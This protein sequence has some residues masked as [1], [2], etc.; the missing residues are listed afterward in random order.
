MKRTAWMIRLALCAL[1]VAAIA[2]PADAAEK[3]IL[4]YLRGS[5]GAPI[6]VMKAQKLAEKHG[7]EID[8]KGFLDVAAMDRAFVLGELDVH[9]NLALNQWAVFLNQG[10]DLVGVL[11]A[12]HPTGFLVVP[13]KSPYRELKDLV[14]KR[15]GVYGIHGTSTAIFG[16]IA[17]GQLGGMDIRK[18]M[19][20]FNSTPPALT[21][22]IAKGEVDAALSLAPFV[23]KMVKSGEYRVLL[24]TNEA[25][26]KLT[27]HALPFAVI[28][29]T[30]KTLEARPKP[31][32][33]FVEAWKESVDYLRKN[34]D[35]LNDYLATGRITAPDE[36]KFAQQM[37]LPH[38][39]NT[40]TPRDIEMI[41]A[42]WDRALK[43]G[44]LDA[45]VKT[46][47]WYTL[48]LA[49]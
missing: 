10:H 20:L 5:S 33:A 13:A 42:Y 34:P 40:W 23:P 31:I 8:A 45:P 35:S 46:Q 29:V 28:A 16:V 9:V 4:G 41:R 7:L 26:T 39:M 22:L 14:G 36:Q 15:V 12:L 48:D 27:G 43:A 24:D 17:H 49:R 3:L 37:M 44:F 18:S 19:K 6:E 2:A 32:R 21:T 47:T 38:Y 25:W 30:R 11:G 1:G